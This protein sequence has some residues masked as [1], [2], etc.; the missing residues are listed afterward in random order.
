MAAAPPHELPVGSSMP[1]EQKC[2]PVDLKDAEIKVGIR[3]YVSPSVRGFRCVIKKRFTDFVVQEVDGD[4]RVASLFDADADARDADARDAGEG[5][6]REKEADNA[7]VRETDP[8]PPPPMSLYDAL[9][10]IAGTEVAEAARPL[11]EVQIRAAAEGTPSEPELSVTLPACADKDVRRSVHA[12]VRERLPLFFSETLEGG[13][14]RV[15][16]RETN[17]GDKKRRR[18]TEYDSQGDGRSAKSKKYAFTYFTLCKRNFETQDCIGAMARVLRVHPSVFGCAGT[19]D[20]RGITLQ[21]VSAKNLAP[22]RLEAVNS[23]RM[24]RLGWNMRV[25]AFSGGDSQIKLGQ[26]R[27]NKFTVTMRNL[28]PPPTVADAGCATASGTKSLVADIAAAMHSMK[29][30]GFI[31]YYGMQR[32]G[33]TSG[34]RTH[35]VGTALLK[36]RWL[37][38]MVLMLQSWRCDPAAEQ[39]RQNMLRCLRAVAEHMEHPCSAPSE[40]GA[41]DLK[42]LDAE[43]RVLAAKLHEQPKRFGSVG[44]KC[45][46]HHIKHN[47]IASGQSQAFVSIPRN[48]R[49]LY[50]HAFQSYVW[51]MAASHRIET[52]G[53]DVAIGDVV[54]PSSERGAKAALPS[55]SSSSVARVLT[56]DD[57][58]SQFSIHDVVLPIPGNAVCYPQNETRKVYHALVEEEGLVLPDREQQTGSHEVESEEPAHSVR[59]FCLSHWPGDYRKLL[60]RPEDVHFKILKYM[61][62][63]EDLI[64]T[65]LTSAADTLAIEKS[66]EV[67]LHDDDAGAIDGGAL[68]SAASKAE[69]GAA[70]ADK[71][72][73]QVFFTLPSSTYATMAIRELTKLSDRELRELTS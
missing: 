5:R 42:S 39:T 52:Y 2:T 67:I 55:A 4:G 22:A 53:L 7:D 65:E 36:G 31:N 26:L 51:N 14:I 30:N 60:C 17:G 64:A 57:D 6:G 19:K 23:Y 45:L 56:A 13:I 32:F 62:D 48:L 69:G 58:L 61:S 20:K 18:W 15:A 10:Q 70:S 8:T 1:T 25:G 43:A 59:E 44:E 68:E 37:H 35:T 47:G 29:S 54:C 40:D 34:V 24:G 28:Q 50:V 46:L 72:A 11:L 33:N 12:F 16:R 3:A 49:V 9:Q 66:V 73:L 38:A 63:D 21:R 27:G 71:I 41:R